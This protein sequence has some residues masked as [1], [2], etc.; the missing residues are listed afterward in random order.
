MDNAKSKGNL[1]TLI[2]LEVLASGTSG[3]GGGGGG[4][5]DDDDEDDDGDGG[6]DGD[7]DDDDDDDDGADQ[8]RKS[9]GDREGLSPQSSSF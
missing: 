7:G 9:W 1:F 4:G 2:A 6:N 5:G 3:G 8:W